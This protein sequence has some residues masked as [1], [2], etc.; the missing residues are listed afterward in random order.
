MTGIDYSYFC[1]LSSV[2]CLSLLLPVCLYLQAIITNLTVP[3]CDGVTVLRAI[4]FPVVTLWKQIV[5]SL[6][7]Q[8]LS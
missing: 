1:R 3:S 8:A 2:L 4:T 6:T 7:D 5:T